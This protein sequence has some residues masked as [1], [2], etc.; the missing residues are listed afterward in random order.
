[1]NIPL[2][3]Q[4]QILSQRNFRLYFTGQAIS[5]TGTWM[6][7]LAGSLVV[8]E[9]TRS[10]F[11]LALVNFAM[12]APGLL[13]MLAG[14]V[15]ADRY[16]RRRILVVT[17]AALMVLA[18]VAGVLVA[19]GAITFWQILVLSA[20]VGV[21]AA[22]DMPAQ[23]ALVPDLVEPRQ[24][25]QAIALNQVIF[26]GS[27]LLGPALAGVLIAAA[28]FASAYLANA[29]SYVAVIAS[30]L[31]VRLPARMAQAGVGGSP[32]AAIG[33]GLRH[34]WGAPVVRALMTVNGLTSLLI[35]PPLAVIST[36]YVRGALGGGSGTTA[37]FFAA[38]GLASMLGAFAMLGVPATR[39][40][41]ATLGCIALQTLT[42]VVLA[43]THSMPVAVVAFGLLS[44]GMGLVYGLNATTIQQVTPSAIRGRV[45][46]VSGLMFSGVMPLAAIVIG[47]AVEPFGIRA[48][49]AVCGAAYALLAAPLLWRS[50]AVGRAPEPDIA[51]SPGP[52]PA[53][54]RITQPHSP[55]S[56]PRAT[57][58][59]IAAGPPGR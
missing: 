6:Q 5:L 39:R 31:M 17:Q 20:L 7:S 12:A 44:L 48:V 14:G 9:L 3:S 45:M 10:T 58:G 47:A 2:P 35:F 43:T 21:A 37:T 32:L 22:F 1:M 11:A 41:A 40:G 51:D 25:P 24:I 46:S 30:L 50:G 36:A 4:F 8:W 52:W 19:T 57:T 26:N 54:R 29:I 56:R 55:A 15:A 23:Q 16:D 33:E 34:V 28:G 49:Y 38:S 27:R 42:L 53:T 13:L 59:S 18:A